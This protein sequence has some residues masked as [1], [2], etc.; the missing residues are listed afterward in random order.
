MAWGPNLC[1]S[2][3]DL[4]GIVAVG[5]ETPLGVP[6]LGSLPQDRVPCRGWQGHSAQTRA[7]GKQASWLEGNLASPAAPISSPLLVA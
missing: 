7:L 2:E 1:N 5:S 4:G 6:L 3:N